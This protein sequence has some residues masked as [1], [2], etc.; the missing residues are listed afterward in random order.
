MKWTR[1]FILQHWSPPLQLVP[2]VIWKLSRS[3]ERT[4]DH[5]AFL[6]RQRR[7]RAPSSPLRPHV[8]YSNHQ[9]HHSASHHPVVASLLA[10]ASMRDPS[11]VLLFMLLTKC[12]GYWGVQDD[13]RRGPPVRCVRGQVLVEEH[14][15]HGGRRSGRIAGRRWGSPGSG[16]T[17]SSSFRL[18]FLLNFLVHTILIF[19]ETRFWNF[20][21][22]RLWT[23]TNEAIFCCFV[24]KFQTALGSHE[25]GGTAW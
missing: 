9:L 6:P 24:D 18:F 13:R 23:R 25:H 1:N 22:T 3:I 17:G 21:C 12:S 10:S 20:G 8:L 19:I 11:S 5:I 14:G 7:W 16:S 2:N 4:P 15:D